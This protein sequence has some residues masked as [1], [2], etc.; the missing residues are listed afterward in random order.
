MTLDERQSRNRLERGLWQQKD[1]K[2]WSVKSETLL[3][4]S[5]GRTLTESRLVTS[6]LMSAILFWLASPSLVSSVA[7][8]GSLTEA[9]M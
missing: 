9:T 3:E 5:N 8:S 6:I 7:A 1:P 2:H 4:I